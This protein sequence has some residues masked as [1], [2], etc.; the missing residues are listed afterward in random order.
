[1]TMGLISEIPINKVLLRN[2]L[3][4]FLTNRGD[5]VDTVNT[6]ETGDKKNTINTIV[7]TTSLKVSLFS[8]TVLQLIFK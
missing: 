8:L 5:T 4:F 3:Q 7:T 1:M 2:E 6:G